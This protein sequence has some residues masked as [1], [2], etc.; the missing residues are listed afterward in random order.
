MI[1]QKGLGFERSVAALPRFARFAL[2]G[3]LNTAVDFLV[4]STLLFLLDCNILVAN[5]ISYLAGTVCSYVLNRSWTFSDR[6]ASPRQHYQALLFLLANLATLTLSTL[7][8]AASARIMPAL[9]AKAVATLAC[10]FVN[11]AAAKHIVFRDRAARRPRLG[12]G[13]T[14]RD[15]AIPIL[16]LLVILAAGAF[17]LFFLRPAPGLA[18]WDESR[19]AVNAIEMYRSGWSLVTTY[20]FQPDL[21]NTK[22]PLMIWLMVLSMKLLGP[23]VWAVR[24]P[25]ALASLA[26]VA[27]TYGFTWRLT[28]SVP[29]AAGAAILLAAS[30]VFIGYHAAAT[31]DCDALLTLFTTAYLALLFFALHRRRPGWAEAAG[32]G[33]VIAAAIM[34]KTIAGLMPGVGVVLYLLVTN[35]W[36]RPLRTGRY[37]AAGILTATIVAAFLALREA[38]APGYLAATMRNDIGGRFF[39]TIGAHTGSTLEYIVII[40]EGG[41]VGGP[42]ILAAPLALRGTRGLARFG[43]LYCLCISVCF[44]AAVSASSTR[45]PWYIEPACPFLSVAVAITIHAAARAA[46]NGP[47]TAPALLRRY[48]PLLAAGAIPVFLFAARIYDLGREGY[49]TQSPYGTLLETLSRQQAAEI[50]V[51]DDGVENDEGIANYAPQLRFYALL[52]QDKGMAVRY[53]SRAALRAAPGDIV[54]T[55]DPKLT[56][57]LSGTEPELAFVA[58]C[59]AI[60]KPG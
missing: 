8:V 11:Y 10:V 7:I 3:G 38:A 19:L 52:W 50:H 22:P 40:L 17:Y 16:A 24:L 54:A 37:L 33:L 46:R 44:I 29:A 60:R 2:V 15:R 56:R 23:S 41:F 48:A 43:L 47:A 12:A 30:P 4:F 28:R 27:V 5:A 42:L 53:S 26:T 57:A 9:A 58:G 20:E 45:L 34:T 31:G 18:L 21:W 49:A 59:A 55:C 32:I 35:R 1:I 14:A 6:A 36:M 39:T 25:S 13:A 51:V